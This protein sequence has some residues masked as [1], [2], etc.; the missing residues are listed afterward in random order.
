[1]TK[2]S[3]IISL[4]MKTTNGK[5]EKIPENSGE[6]NPVK[7]N[8]GKFITNKK[9]NVIIVI[10]GNQMIFC[11]QVIENFNYMWLTQIKMSL[12]ALELVCLHFFYQFNSGY[13]IIQGSSRNRAYILSFA[14]PLN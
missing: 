14:C 4:D 8:S 5:M 7:N 11:Y 6:M 1:M 13:V 10:D 9:R 2:N 3:Q 12:R